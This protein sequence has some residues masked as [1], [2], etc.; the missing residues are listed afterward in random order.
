MTPTTAVLR[1]PR[2]DLIPQWRPTDVPR[3]NRAEADNRPLCGC[4]R[5]GIN[6]RHGRNQSEIIMHTCAGLHT[7]TLSHSL[8]CEGVLIK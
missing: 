1:P 5:E 8:F 3:D 6:I 2:T 7:K 4:W